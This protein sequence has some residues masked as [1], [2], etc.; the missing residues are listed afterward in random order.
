MTNKNDTEEYKYPP[1]MAWAIEIKELKEDNVWLR[2]SRY[3][4]ERL[5]RYAITVIEKSGKEE[6]FLDALR[7]WIDLYGTT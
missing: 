2:K 4:V 5:V 1:R 3:E 7:D 6:E